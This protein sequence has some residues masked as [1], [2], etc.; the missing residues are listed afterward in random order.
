[1]NLEFYDR[2]IRT[3]GLDNF[4]LINK[5][6]ILLVGLQNG[7]GTEIAKHLVLNGINKLYL[8]DSNLINESDLLNGYYYQHNI[9]K[10]RS[11]ILKNKLS[12]LNSEVEII[13]VDDFNQ[14]QD[15]SILINQ[16]INYILGIEKYNSKLILLFSYNFSGSIF[17]DA[18]LNLYYNNTYKC[19][20]IDITQD[21]IIKCSQN[22]NFSNNDKIIFKDLDG[23]NLEYFYKEWK[24]IIISNTTFKLLNYEIN[25]FE[26][27][28][29]H[30]ENIKKLKTIN[31]KKFSD[32]LEI[33]S[34]ILNNN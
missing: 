8:L 1:M 34:K 6:S 24:I 10:K 32:E 9:G 30:C 15:I 23:K 22:H 16:D 20:I 29:G 5:S 27:I 25:K 7:L 26:F 3:L 21:G 14:N 31:N 4:N 13:L 2:E 17:I 11:D 12:E 19:R 33:N 18:N 28:N